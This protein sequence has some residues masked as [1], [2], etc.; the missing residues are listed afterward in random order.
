MVT[1]YLLLA[2]LIFSTFAPSAEQRVAAPTSDV[3]IAER[4]RSELLAALDIGAGAS[5]DVSFSAA[6][7][8][9]YLT[10]VGG[11]RVAYTESSG[12][13]YSAERAIEKPDGLPGP[14]PKFRRGSNCWW[15]WLLSGIDICG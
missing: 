7:V 4:L 15:L 1:H 13:V 2:A 12:E 3:T 11:V 14:Q 5:E 10:R 9:P 6:H 8:N